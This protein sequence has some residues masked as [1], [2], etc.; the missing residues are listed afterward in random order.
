MKREIA[1]TDYSHWRYA[2]GDKVKKFNF[3]IATR[4]FRNKKE[5]HVSRQEMCNEILPFHLIFNWLLAFQEIFIRDTDD[6]AVLQ[7]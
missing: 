2:S 6:C 7:I 4:K 1:C 5:M 3:E